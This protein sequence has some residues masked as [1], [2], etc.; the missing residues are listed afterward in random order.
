MEYFKYL[1]NF[2]RIM[3]DLK[4]CD[5]RSESGN[6]HYIAFFF[7]WF[8]YYAVTMS[9]PILDLIIET[10]MFEIW[11]LWQPFYELAGC[12]QQSFAFKSFKVKK[13]KKTYSKINFGAKMLVYSLQVECVGVLTWF[14]NI[15]AMRLTAVSLSLL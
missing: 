14:S 3:L 10:R 5:M 12:L 13:E 4:S 8:W 15:F 2:P 9:T 6:L 11:K 1:I 7:F